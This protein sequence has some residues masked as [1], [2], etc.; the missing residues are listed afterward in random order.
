MCPIRQHGSGASA[1]M[2][3]DREW[4]AVDWVG[5][6]G[7]GLRKMEDGYGGWKWR[8]M[9]RDSTMSLS[10]WKAIL[11]S[12]PVANP[13]CSYFETYLSVRYHS[14]TSNSAFINILSLQR[15]NQRWAHCNRRLK[16]CNVP[17]S[18]NSC[19]DV[20][21][22]GGLRACSSWGETTHTTGGRLTRRKESDGR[23]GGKERN[24]I[25]KEFI[26]QWE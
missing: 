17:N 9:D 16:S 1:T 10:K 12:A 7:G 6:V 19:G 20:P 26:I 24:A 11:V 5:V 25:D 21:N 14:Y 18:F 22:Y 2:H 23:L 15:L 3:N 13:T 4:V 8:K